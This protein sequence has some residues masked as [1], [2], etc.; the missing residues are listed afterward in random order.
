MKLFINTLIPKLQILNILIVYNGQTAWRKAVAEI[1]ILNGGESAVNFPSLGLE[2]FK[3]T[4][5]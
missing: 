5:K 4:L 3:S 2:V 1:E